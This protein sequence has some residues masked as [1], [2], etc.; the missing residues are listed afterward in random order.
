MADAPD[1]PVPQQET[2]GRSPFQNG[3]RTSGRAFNSPNWRMKGEESPSARDSGSPGPK[4]TTSRLTFGKLNSQ[5]PPAISEGRRLYVGNMPY[6][7]KSEDVEALF[8]ATKF[9][10]ERIDIA[11]DPFT[12]RNPSYCFVDLDTKESAERAMNELDGSDLLGRP[13][14]IKPGVAKSASERAQQQRTEGAPRGD[15]TSSS[16][17]S[18]SPFA[19]DRWRRNDAPT[20]PKVNS[21][22]SRRVYVGG[23][24]KVIDTEEITTKITDFFK[25]YK[26][27]N[28]SKLFTPHPAKRFEAGD[29]YYLFVEF[30][31]VEEA[32][33]AMDTLN[34]Q[35]GP[36]GGNLRVQRARG[37]T[38][39][40]EERKAR[41]SSTRGDAN[42]APVTDE[43]AGDV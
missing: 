14:K 29:H 9:P 34:G 16:S 27:E 10:I 7:A 13:V 8:T 43:V 33:T 25:G 21:D 28:V 22:T 24:P 17:S 36:W 1:S 5:V 15:R 38:Y 26:V 3:V 12:G 37:E 19:A 2:P 11:I 4:T 39:N 40:S 20:F 32:Q 30:S 35:Q 42:D 41:W 23:L 31:S 18:S 6:T